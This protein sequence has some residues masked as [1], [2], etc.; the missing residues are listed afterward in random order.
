MSEVVRVERHD[1]V[2]VIR[3]DRPK[4]NALDA[5]VVAGLNAACAQIEGDKTIRAAVVYG[6]ERTF[7]AGADLKEMA[8]GSPEDVR[9]RV[10]AL[11]RVCDRIESLFVVTI[12]A[13]NGYALGG[14]CELALACDFRFVAASARLG[15]PEIVVGLIPGA[16]GTQR[17]P[18]LVGPARARRMIYTGDF[19]DAATA[20][21][22]GL[23][24]E[25][26]EGD[27]LQAALEQAARY[28][29]GPT[30]SLAAAKRAIN[31][32]LDG[33]LSA[34][35]AIELDEFTA[36]FLTEDTRHGLE[37]FA[38]SGPGKA[39]YKGK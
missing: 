3:I 39:K 23:A 25:I 36:L 11:Q 20:L 10:G 30:L 34:G 7:S 1:A 29:S 27:V 37:S 6:G 8:Q 32:G 15:Q 28:A 13:I 19:V 38:A 22:W 5:A 18:R 4:V 35:L 14:G 33:P 21:E 9:G 31:R 17:L 26:V 2:G 24:D 12:A 16:G